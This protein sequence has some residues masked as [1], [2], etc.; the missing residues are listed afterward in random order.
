MKAHIVGGGF[1]GLAAAALLIRN[2]DVP[3]QDITIYEAGDKLGG[4]FFLD[5][6]AESGYNL[7]GSIFDKEFR[8]AFDLLATIPT[9]DDAKIS[10]KEQYFTFNADHPWDDRVH[11]VDSDLR[12]VHGPRYGLTLWEGLTLARLS[13]T[14][15]SWLSGRRIEEFFSPRFFKTE[16]WLLWSTLMGSLPQH[17]VIEFRRYMNRFVYLF[18]DLSTMAHVQRSPLNQHEAFIK[19]LLAWLRPRK[20]NFLTGVF[21][22]DLGFE[23]SPGR[24]SVN[25]LDYRRHGEEA[26]VAIAPDDIVLVTT[27]SQAADRSAGTMKTAPPPP[28]DS[29]QSWALWK[30]L[31]T[32]RKEFGNPDTFFGADK[33][34]DSRW[35]TFTVITKGTEFIDQMT[36]LTLSEPGS[37]GLLT[38]RD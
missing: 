30:R 5:G 27:G 1:G 18:P 32:G 15:E 9:E 23:Q 37:G 34:A 29:G 25:R 19:P 2:A 36:R 4:G 26:S 20:V 10:V 8:C 38:L 7:P 13:L 12:T 6:S 35:V 33:A 21:V 22:Q 31:A 3:G 14:P 16:F 28:Q 17:S 24:I 11:I